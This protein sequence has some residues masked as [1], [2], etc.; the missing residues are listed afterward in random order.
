[1]DSLLLV[2]TLGSLTL[3][4]VMSVIAWRLLRLNAERRAARVEAL[5]AMAAADVEPNAAEL[6][7]YQFTQT[8]ET[9]QATETRELFLPAEHLPA[10]RWPARLGVVVAITACA[11][12]PYA[13]YS[14]G[15]FGAIATAAPAASAPVELLSLRHSTDDPG[16]FTVT[17]LIQN[18]TNGRKTGG[19][20]AVVYLFDDAGRFITTGR[21][22]LDA[23]ALQPG[24][25]ATFTVAIPKA[26]GVGKYRV[27]FRFAEGGVVAHID[28]RGQAPAETS[29]D[30]V[31]AA[32]R[33]STSMPFLPPSRSEGE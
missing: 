29:E 15:V 26:S 18:P 2:A 30:A 9:S 3:G 21:A 24:E 5:Q 32:P 14:L 27:G 25:E 12:L 22:P 4:T 11:A 6:D 1:M 13:L 20:I 16:V 28:R 33:R 23:G 17:G 8:D 31:G 7:D 10:A 19:I